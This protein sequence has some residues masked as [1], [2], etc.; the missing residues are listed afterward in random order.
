MTERIVIENTAQTHSSADAW[1]RTDT[2]SNPTTA[3]V[4][5][6]VEQIGGEK[7]YLDNTG[8]D[9]INYRITLRYNADIKLNS[10]LKWGTRYFRINDIQGDRRKGDMTLMCV[11]EALS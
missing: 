11:D 8:R 6:A 3:T 5:A 7:R 9:F 10:R 1:G 2:F 4:W